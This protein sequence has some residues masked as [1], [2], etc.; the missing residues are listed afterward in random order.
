MVL[1]S[2]RSVLHRR[3]SRVYLID[4]DGAP[5]ASRSLIEW[6][7]IGQPDGCL[8]PHNLASP[9]QK[10]EM[11]MSTILTEE[12]RIELNWAGDLGACWLGRSAFKAF[13]KAVAACVANRA[14]R[15]AEAELMA[16]DHRPFQ[17]IGLDRSEIGSV[18]MNHARERR[19]SLQPTLPL[20]PPDPRVGAERRRIQQEQSAAGTAC[21]RL[22]PGMQKPTGIHRR[23]AEPLRSGGIRLGHRQAVQHS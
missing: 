5:F 4:T 12:P 2:G 21:L 19:N 15:R 8:R 20:T 9:A 1:S 14:L 23:C 18:L 13:I 10:D 11:I 6:R 17:D 16:L 7:P 3:P 22:S